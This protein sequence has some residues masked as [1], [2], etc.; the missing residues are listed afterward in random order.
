MTSSQ[1]STRV[2]WTTVFAIVYAL[3]PVVVLLAIH[4]IWANTWRQTGVLPHGGSPVHLGGMEKPI[5]YTTFVLMAASPLVVL[6]NAILL[7]VKGHEPYESQQS[8]RWIVGS[9]VVFACITWAGG[10]VVLM[11]DPFGAIIWFLD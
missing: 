5:M 8:R 7:W 1:S 10:Y 6:A 11:L 2:R 9:L 4:G 3:Y